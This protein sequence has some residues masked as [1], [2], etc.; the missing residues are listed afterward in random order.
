MISTSSRPRRAWVVAGLAMALV[1]CGT[2]A[3]PD[4]GLPSAGLRVQTTATSFPVDSPVTV[5]VVN[6]SSDTLML[7]GCCGSLTVA[8]DQWMGTA[9]QQF[10][11]GYCRAMCPL[12]PLVLGPGDSV[13]GEPTTRLDV[14]QYRLH[15]GVYRPGDT[16]IDWS[17]VSNGFDVH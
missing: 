3:N 4:A 11:G 13:V 7:N 17:A 16:T 12:G 14:G 15:V 2:T 1:A 5:S 8:V 10:A 6:I 9:W